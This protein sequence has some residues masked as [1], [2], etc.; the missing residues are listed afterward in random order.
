[1]SLQECFELFLRTKQTRCRPQ[2]MKFYVWLCQNVGQLADASGHLDTPVNTI[3]RAVLEQWVIGLYQ[4]VAAG[5]IKDTTVKKMVKFLK[6]FFAYL[7]DEG[8]VD[9]DPA[10]KLKCRIA[11]PVETSPFTSANWLN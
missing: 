11:R 9:N 8:F 3:S 2:T 4:R 7:A 1:M 10:V 6:Q 5:E